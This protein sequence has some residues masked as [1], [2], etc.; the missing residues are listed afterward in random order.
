MIATA[1]HDFNPT[2]PNQLPLRKGAKVLVIGKEGDSMG[3][4]RGKTQERVS[5]P[6]CWCWHTHGSHD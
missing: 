5:A 3:W 1:Q 4:W 2:E 6:T